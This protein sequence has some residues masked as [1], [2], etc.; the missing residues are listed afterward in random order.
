MSRREGQSGTAQPGPG[1]DHAADRERILSAVGRLRAQWKADGRH[2]EA[3]AE[4]EAAMRE[5]VR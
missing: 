4:L 2:P 3:R 5:A 1:R